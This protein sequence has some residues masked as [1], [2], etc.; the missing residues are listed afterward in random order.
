VK[1]PNSGDRPIESGDQPVESNGPADEF[2]VIDRLRLR[3]EAAARRSRPGEAVPPPGDTWIG[4]DAAVVALG[5]GQQGIWATDLVVEGVHVDLGLCGLDDVGYKAVMVAVSDLA[6]MG[7]RPHYALVSI[8]AAPGTDLDRVGEGAAAAAADTDCAV[9]GGDLSEGPVLMI[10]VAVLGL[11]SGDAVPPLLR[12]GAR[13]GDRLLVTGPL[14]GSAAGLRLLRSE[15]DTTGRV[16]GDLVRAYRRPQARLGEGE[17]ARLSGATAAIDIS[18]GLISEVRH[19]GGASGVGVA[20]E[21]VP[22]AEGATEEEA[23]GGGEEYELL[24]ATP[25]PDR[26]VR[27]FRS[28]GLRA[29]VEVGECTTRAGEYERAG[30]PLPTAG[31]R[32]RF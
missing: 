20:L 1:S 12:S 31:W 17:A 13:P 28:A 22:V 19:L 3:F 14:G 15:A 11:Q 29:P 7:V 6:A 18:D 5:A 9:V 2:A 23:L 26:L 16:E 30:V 4:D 27:E 32:H 25:D 24:V 10:S 21:R 8:A